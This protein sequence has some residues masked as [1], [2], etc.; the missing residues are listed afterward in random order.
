MVSTLR[1]YL[2]IRQMRRLTDGGGPVSDSVDNVT[3]SG[4][5]GQLGRGV[6]VLLDVGSDDAGGV[7]SGR[8]GSG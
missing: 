6:L 2:P 5:D 1:A 7:G 4:S 3:E 8:T